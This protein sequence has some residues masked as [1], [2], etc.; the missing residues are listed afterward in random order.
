MKTPWEIFEVCFKSH[1]RF[2]VY[3]VITFIKNVHC[4]STQFYPSII[5]GRIAYK[6]WL[7]F[8][9]GTSIYIFFFLKDKYM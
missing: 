4:T 9:T 7:N 3:K 1:H 8:R 5:K 6:M 2:L